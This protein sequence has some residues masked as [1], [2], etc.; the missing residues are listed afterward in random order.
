MILKVIRD[1]LKLIDLPILYNANFGHTAPIITIPYGA[2]AQI[3]CENK[4]F[5]IVESGVS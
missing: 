3:D 4:T 2:A 1:E 5:S